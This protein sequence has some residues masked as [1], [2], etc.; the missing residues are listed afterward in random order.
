MNPYIS[1]YDLMH[2]IRQALDAGFSGHTF[3]ILAETTDIKIYHNRQYAFFNLVEKQGD[4]IVAAAGGVIWKNNFH[5]IRDFE[6]ATGVQFNQ[7]LELVMEVEMQFHERYGLRLSVI[8]IDTAFTLGKIEQERELVLRKLATN[9]PRW[10][11]LEDGEYVSANQ[12]LKKPLVMQRIA[13]IAAPGSDGRRD[14]LQEL[15]GNTWKLAY[16]VTEFPASVQG[17]HAAA[18]IYSGLE[19]IARRH[20][21][22]DAIALVRGGG[23][24]TDFSAFD[25]YDVAKAIASCPKP[26]FTGI[27]HDR[28]IS[29]ADVVAH[30]SL[31]TP[32]R[33][34]AAMTENNLGFL[35]FVQDAGQLI[36]SSARRFI[37]QGRR[38][39]EDK[40]RRLQNAAGWRVEAEKNRLLQTDRHLEMLYPVRTLA[41]GYA[42]VR[43]N[44][45]VL[46]SVADMQP[47]DKVQIRLADGNR[48]AIITEES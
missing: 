10:L 30:E 17:A 14:F 26:V 22:F 19:Q 31:K 18:E 40:K 33:C 23:G 42:M 24:N 1:L 6:K 29:V 7:N 12:L 8:D 43:K 44:G 37:D 39:M 5:L 20:H 3:R 2:G 35:S 15:Q 25:H 11:W 32:T 28:N 48:D 47:G 13:L 46:R 27:G 34:A 38:D 4:E 21:D 36:A 45:K 9:E 16:A 41:A